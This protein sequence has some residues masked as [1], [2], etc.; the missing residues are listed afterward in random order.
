MKYVDLKSN[1]A[2]LVTDRI[3]R[4][5]FTGID[6]AEGYLVLSKNT[7][8]FTDARYFFAAKEKIQPL[9]IQA[10]LYKKHQYNT[11]LGYS[12]RHQHNQLLPSFPRADTPCFYLNPAWDSAIFD[13]PFAEGN[14]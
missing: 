3:L 10:L 8:Y 13:Q 5:Y 9:N 14:I 1:E 6:I 12:D 2:F 7:A 4:N 11:I